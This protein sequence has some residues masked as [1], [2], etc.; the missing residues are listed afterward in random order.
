MNRA[1]HILR[2]LLVALMTICF[3]TTQLVSAGH[4]HS[5]DEK[6]LGEASHHSQFDHVH[7]DMI[8]DSGHHHDDE[9]PLNA[10]CAFC[11][12]VSEDFQ[13]VFTANN[14]RDIFYET[15]T[16]LVSV[17]PSKIEHGIIAN[18]RAVGT[19]S[20]YGLDTPRAPPAYL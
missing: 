11:L 12:A 20:S 8:A 5:H 16:P 17:N 6:H 19:L 15:I 18:I 13:I 9:A 4:N 3:V 2:Y 7:E 10:T 1:A 14:L